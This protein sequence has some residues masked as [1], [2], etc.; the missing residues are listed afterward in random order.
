MGTRVLEEKEKKEH[1][2]AKAWR[3]KV[4]SMM[5]LWAVSGA[6]NWPGSNQCML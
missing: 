4:K 5:N 3:R 6:F 1:S 2:R